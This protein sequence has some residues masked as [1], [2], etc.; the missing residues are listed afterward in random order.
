MATNY[1]GAEQTKM[2]DY[3]YGD[4]DP[5]SFGAYSAVAQQQTSAA[6]GFPGME[7]DSQ[8]R[9]SPTRGRPI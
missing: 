3:G 8:R 6:A 7:N 2:A 4:E 5:Y 1:Y 9:R